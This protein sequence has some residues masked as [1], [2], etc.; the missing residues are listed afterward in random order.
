MKKSS[1]S[2][3]YKTKRNLTLVLMISLSLIFLI[4]KN[5]QF[6]V[7][8]EINFFLSSLFLA[9]LIVMGF[10]IIDRT[11]NAGFETKHYI[12]VAV[13][14]LASFILGGSLYLAYPP[15]DKILHFFQP[16]MFSSIIFHLVR[17]LKIKLRWKLVFTFFIMVGLI[18]MFEIAEFGLDKFFDLKLQGVFVASLQKG[19]H[20]SI[21]LDP[22]SDTH[23]DMIFGVLGSLAYMI[24]LAFYLRKKKNK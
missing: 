15:Y 18:G 4:L 16:M 20:L 10:Y 11:F 2:S 14:V 9:L 6:F 23:M 1:I 12:F 7:D 17:K 22:L 19:G 5:I 24:F 8:K 3:V 21:V 13:I